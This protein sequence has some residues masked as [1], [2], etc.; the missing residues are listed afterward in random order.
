MREVFFSA[1]RS[2]IEAHGAAQPAR[3]RVRGHPLG[4]P[5]NARPD[6][7]PGAVGARPAD[8]PVP[9]ARRAA[10]PPAAMGRRAPRGDLDPARAADRRA[11]R[12]SWSRRCV[13]A[14]NGDSGAVAAV[15]E[16]AGGNPFF[17]E[18][19]ARRLADEAGGELF[20]LPDT[21]QG[22]LAARLDSLEPAERVLVQHAAVVGRTFWEGSLGDRP[23][24]TRR[25]PREALQRLQE[26]DIIVPDVGVRLAGEREYSFKH[27]L[28]RDVAYGMLPQGG[29]LRASTSRSA[30]S[31]RTAPASAPT[32][33]SRCWPS[34]SAAPRRSATRPAWTAPR[35]SRSTA[36]RS[37]T[38][39]PPATRPRALY[40]NPEAYEHYEAARQIECPHDPGDGRARDREAGRRR[41]PHGPRRHR[42]RAVGGVR[43][44]TT[45]SR[46][47][48]RASP[49][50]TARSARACGTAASASSRS[51][52]TRRASTC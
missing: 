43:S 33:W 5:R 17:A 14:E 10:R 12:A 49:T 15:A 4:R 36:R 24:T 8:P 21:V 18:E 3:A 34:T 11:R 28:I 42:R 29:P 27:V 19:M 30:A 6:R 7:V 47:T 26:K 31:S 9:G 51:S 2:V 52:A 37:T 1:V 22:L 40:S 32:R 16:R 39:R 45:A 41:V 35:S 50:C 38:W 44:S 25:R 23:A 20:E 48:S 13:G 46:R